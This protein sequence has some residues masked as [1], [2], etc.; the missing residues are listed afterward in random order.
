MF[1]SFPFFS[2]YVPL[3]VYDVTPLGSTT[4]YSVR[5]SVLSLLKSLPI[6]TL[7]SS[8]TDCFGLGPPIMGNRTT[9]N[10]RRVKINPEK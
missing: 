6:Y 2:T 5:Y 4:L 1:V 8:A 7:V 9:N 3:P 10:R